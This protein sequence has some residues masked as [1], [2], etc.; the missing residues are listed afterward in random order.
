M[1]EWKKVIVSGSKAHLNEVTASKFTGD[2]SALTGVTATELGNSLIDGNGIS[3]FTFDASA[4]VSVSVEAD[5]STIAVGASGIKVAD[6]QLNSTQLKTDTFAANGGL[7]GGNGTAVALDIDGMTDI[8]GNLASG[9][10]FIV[11]DGGGGTNR[12]TSVDRIATLFAG[13]GLTA[14]SGVIGV[15]ASQTQITSVGTLGAGGISSGF[16]NID[17]GTSTLNAGNAT[18]DT[19]VNDSSIAGSR[20]SGSFTGSFTGDG[21]GL[22]GIAFEIDSLD[23]ATIADAD[24]LAFADDNDSGNEKKATF[25]AIALAAVDKIAGDVNV[26]SSGASVIAAD[27][28]HGTMLNTDAADTTTLELS[29]NSLSVLKVP[30]ALTVDDSTI[31]LNSGTTYD[32]AAARTVSIKDGGVTLAKQANMAADSIQGRANGAGTGAPQALSAAQVRTIINVENGATADQ[33]AVEIIGALNSDLGGDFTIGNQSDDLATFSG[34]VKV[35]GDLTVEGSTVSAQVANLTVEDRFAL[36]NSGSSDA[37]GGII[38]QTESDFS[39]VALGWD[40]SAQRFATQVD[41]K[42]AYDAT[43]IAPDAYL[44]SVVADGSDDATYRKNGNIRVDGSGD[45]HIYVE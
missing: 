43:A 6:N 36:F 39:G 13:T 1:A 12:K 8:G 45:I 44:A 31:A 41:T 33:T 17:I 11:D 37:D 5:G 32:G 42:L 2:G 9:D 26:D 10:L 28:V 29:S 24:V 4:G 38:I 3:D 14:A 19:L 21:S 40:H 34:P 27:S 16:G 20:I 25:S 23:T 22:S 18:V 35:V 7:A 30:N 15:D